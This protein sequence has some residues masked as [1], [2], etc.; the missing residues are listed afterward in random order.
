MGSLENW[1]RRQRGK[2]LVTLG[3]LVQAGDKA[4]RTGKSPL[5]TKHVE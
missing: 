1:T 4:M 3:P 5:S 2:D